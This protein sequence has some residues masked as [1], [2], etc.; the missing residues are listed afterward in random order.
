LAMLK[1]LMA[2]YGLSAVESQGTS[3]GIMYGIVQ[4]QAALL[5]INDTFFVTT[6]IAFITIFLA[7]MFGGK[8][9]AATVGEK[10]VMV[11]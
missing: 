6:G 4:K 9:P 1:G 8:K 10:Q 11:E 5:A 7:M 2:Q 3:I